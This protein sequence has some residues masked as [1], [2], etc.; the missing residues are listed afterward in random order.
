[1]RTCRVWLARSP[2]SQHFLH[3]ARGERPEGK[4]GGGGDS[5]EEQTSI[6]GTCVTGGR[7]RRPCSLCIYILKM[8]CRSEMEPFQEH[9]AQA[10]AA[11]MTGG[12]QEKV[13][14]VDAFVLDSTAS[15]A[16]TPGR[17]TPP[18]KTSTA[19]CPRRL[20]ELLAQ[21]TLGGRERPSECLET[22][23]ETNSCMS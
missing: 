13:A 3:R 11:E 15:K 4:I 5:E 20:A 1:M 16:Q 19:C 17:A 22:S 6:M 2:D 8:R 14:D 23:L 12:R 10:S 21:R 7:Q 18:T 9:G